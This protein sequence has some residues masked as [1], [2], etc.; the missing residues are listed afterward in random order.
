[1]VIDMG[2]WTKVGKRLLIFILTII[3]IILAM[4]L[5]VFYMPFLIA[6]IISLLIEPLIKIVNKKTKLTRKVSAIL[7]LILVFAI[8]IGLLVWGSTSLISEASNLLS[9]LNN[10]IEQIYIK[11]TNYIEK[12]DFDKLQISEEVTNII[13]QSTTDLLKN[14]ST[15]I[16]K[17]LTSLLD[18]VTSIPTIGVYT[19]ITILATYFICTDKIY[20]IDQIEH[21]TPKAWV[22]KFTIHLKEITSKLGSYLKAEVILIGI[23]FILLL[24]G[25]IIIKFMGMNVEYPLLVAL[26]IG[27]V[28]A[29]PILG[30]GTIMIPW[31][32]I[33]SLNGDISLAIALIILYIIILVTR[34]FLEPKIIGNQ[35]GIHPIFTL[36]AMYT[37]YRMIGVFGMLIGPIVLII[38]ESIF[39]TLIEKGILKTIFDKK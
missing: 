27:F 19:V 29:L 4:K 3:G 7:V 5:A 11:I 24:I 34:Q 25:L 12:I 15:W 21:H 22:R 14:V 2:Y 31:A 8:I 6:F 9:G 17:F 36:I 26:L 30:S 32:V 39:G 16:T 1:M 20:I 10:N 28:D 18:I 33:S 23:D 35:I 13:K 38:L 37:G